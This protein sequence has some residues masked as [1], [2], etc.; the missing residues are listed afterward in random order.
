MQHA[1]CLI[2]DHLVRLSAVFPLVY[3]FL[4]FSCLFKTLLK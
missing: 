4:P 2:I 1:A 3:A